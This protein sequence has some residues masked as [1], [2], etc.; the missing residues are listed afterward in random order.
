MTLRLKRS[1]VMVHPAFLYRLT[2]LAIA[3]AGV[4]RGP[5]MQFLP[6]VNGRLSAASSESL[7]SLA[8]DKDEESSE[9]DACFFRCFLFLDE[10]QS[11]FLLFLFLSGLVNS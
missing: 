7:D 3:W 6:L 5:A 8:E 11:D 4:G 10:A 9:E 1:T 2:P